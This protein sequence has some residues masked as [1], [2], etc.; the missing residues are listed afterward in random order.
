MLEKDDYKEVEIYPNEI[1]IE[2]TRGSGNGGQHRNTTDSCVI[3]THISTG[4]KVVRDSR[5]QH[6]NKEEA[7]DEL[8]KRVNHF[9]RTGHMADEVEERREQIGTGLR[10]DK[11]RTYRVKDDSV[12]D[13][14]TGKN[15]SFKQFMKGNLELLF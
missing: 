10:S 11:R 7:I 13:H 8:K 4:I 5:N 3:V 14:V 15:C 6:K 1:R 9:Y 2:T 12:C